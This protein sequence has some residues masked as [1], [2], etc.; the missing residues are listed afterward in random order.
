MKKNMK[1]VIF[2]ILVCLIVCLFIVKLFLNTS[3]E[4]TCN[5]FDLN[6]LV[7]EINLATNNSFTNLQNSNMSMYIP[8]SF[9]KDVNYIF[10]NTP[11]KETEYFI[12]AQ[13]L[14]ENELL[15][16][17]DFVETNN[18]LYENN[19]IKMGTHGEYTYAIYS[20]RYNSIIEGI[21]RSYIY[22]N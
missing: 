18:K 16:L 2:L 12:I 19:Q 13:N 10:L 20:D 6:D 22:C 15:D 5:N 11:E 7:N 8:V 14:S 17:N 4:E 1:F 21:I 3:K 9:T